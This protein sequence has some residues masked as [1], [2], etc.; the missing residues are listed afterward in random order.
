M[1][2]IAIIPIKY[3]SSRV[4]KKNY[5]LM[6]GKPLFWYVINTLSKSKLI[7]RIIINIDDV[8]LQ[9]KIQT[10]FPSI[11]IYMRP[12]KLK[13]DNIST[14]LLFI[15]MIESLKLDRVYNVFLQTHITN[16]LVKLETFDKIIDM[17]DVLIYSGHDS[18]FS[19]KRLQTRLYD[20][21][22]EAVNHNPKEL[23]PTQDLNPIYEENSCI[24]V[25]S[26]RTLKKNNHRIGERPYMFEMSNYES[27][28]IDYEFDFTVTEMM[29]KNNDTDKV[30]VVTGSSGGI[31]SAIYNKLQKMGWSVV[32]LDIK[33]SE[34]TII[35]DLSDLSSIDLAVNKIKEKYTHVDLLV[36]N[37]AIQICKDWD[38]YDMDDWTKTLNIN[39]RSAYYLSKSLKP[40]LK[41]GS[42]VNIC[43]VHSIATS[44][45]I[46]LYAMSKGSL[47]S[48]TRSMSLEYIKDNI[49]IN[50][51]SP[52]AI[53]TPM[54]RDGLE[55]SSDPK[56]SLKRLENNCPASRIGTPEEIADSIYFL[57]QNNFIVGENLVVDGG[58]TIKLSTE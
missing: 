44:P 12:N 10:Y 53:D 16:P 21:L 19:V 14:N 1:K 30:A 35:T 49:R 28:D 31:G 8:R 27:Q 50:A 4:P 40:L 57:Y 13:G 5:R 11:E 18:A 26:Y 51:I 41:G 42:I 47:L 7:D 39:V 6:N 37:G 48:L 32:G 54:L 58:T 20:N 29:M 24:Y 25:F 55:R 38:S 9:E 23:I 22:G 17:Y 52:G 15:D 46:G 43:S 56:K 34:N 45:G 3:H 33:L 2:V 36:N